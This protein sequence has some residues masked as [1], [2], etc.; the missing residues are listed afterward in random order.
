[1]IL[2]FL[3]VS[4][5]EYRLFDLLAAALLFTSWTFAYILVYPASQAASPSFR[6]LYLIGRAKS[7]GIPENQIFSS[8][9]NEDLFDARLHDLM[10]A[11][12]VIREGE[13]LGATAK[14]RALVSPFL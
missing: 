8:F 14:G 3:V 7:Q 13:M 5:F 6:I 4:F 11:G 10:G 1:M 9:E 2:F 12:L